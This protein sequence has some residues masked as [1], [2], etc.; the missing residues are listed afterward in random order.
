MSLKLWC[1]WQEHSNIQKAISSLEVILQ[2]DQEIHAFSFL[3]GLEKLIILFYITLFQMPS[4]IDLNR[5]VFF[6]FSRFNSKVKITQARLWIPIKVDWMTGFYINF[7]SDFS[8]LLTWKISHWLWDNN[9]SNIWDTTE[10]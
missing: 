7:E 2:F 6:G 8:K 10:K 3:I 9:R 1:E 4:K 5:N